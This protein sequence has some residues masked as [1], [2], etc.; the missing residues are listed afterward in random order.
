MVVYVV[1]CAFGKHKMR[2]HC[3]DANVTN[4]SCVTV[5]RYS[6]HSISEA[7]DRQFLIGYC[8]FAGLLHFVLL[9]SIDSLI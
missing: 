2:R 1:T 8:W 3:L 5:P 9:L 7:E 6:L 4:A